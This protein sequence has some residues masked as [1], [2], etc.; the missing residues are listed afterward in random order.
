MFE[1]L[2][3]LCEKIQKKWVEEIVESVTEAAE[4]F[5]TEE[6]CK[7]LVL[8]SIDEFDKLADRTANGYDDWFI[9]VLRRK[10]DENWEW[11]WDML[12]EEKLDEEGEVVCC[13]YGN[14]FP[15]RFCDW[16]KEVKSITEYKG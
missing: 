1:K 10:V 14:E 6:N 13:G 4:A 5:L 12:F 2:K 16:V 3:D 9:G 15:E 8:R 11:V 7:N